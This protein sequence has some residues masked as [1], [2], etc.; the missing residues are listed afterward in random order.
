MSLGT[1]AHKQGRVAGENAVGGQTEFKGSLGTQVVNIS[2]LVIARPGLRDQE[3]MDEIFD[4]LTVQADSW[5]HKAYYPG[6]TKVRNRI[7]GD[8]K[9][10]ILE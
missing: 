1:V 9:R 5:D 8:L 7:R 2:D 10:R 6:A 4:P 3:A